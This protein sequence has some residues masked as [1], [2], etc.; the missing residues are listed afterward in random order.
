MGG[1]HQPVGL[2]VE[3]EPGP[4]G[5]LHLGEQEQ[6]FV[7]AKIGYLPEIQ[8]VSY[9][10]LSPDSSAPIQSIAAQEF[11]NYPRNCQRKV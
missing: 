10:K 11:V 3:F 5:K 2:Q 6:P 4:A 7:G 1:L 9:T 8:G